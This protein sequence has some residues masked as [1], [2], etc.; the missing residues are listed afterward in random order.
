MSSNLEMNSV[1]L[2]ET[3]D[4]LKNPNALHK[5]GQIIYKVHEEKWCG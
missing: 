2:E 5:V 1:P 4:G 3:E